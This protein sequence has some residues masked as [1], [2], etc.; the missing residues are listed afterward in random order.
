M[1]ANNEN[2]I[3]PGEGN[4][5]TLQIPLEIKIDLG[6]MQVIGDNLFHKGSSGSKFFVQENDIQNVREFDDVN[7][8]L[9]RT[10]LVKF[11]E[12]RNSDYYNEDEDHQ[13]RDKYFQPINGSASAP[14]FYRQLN[15][16]VSRTHK[17]QLKYKP[18]V[19]LYPDVDL[20][21]DKTIHSIYSGIEYESEKLILDDF[22][23]DQER[24]MQLREMMQKRV[25]WGA[26]MLAQELD[27]LESSLPYNCEH[28]V[29]QSWFEKR[30]P[31]RGDLHHLFAC[32]MTCNSFRGNIPYWRGD[33]NGTESYYLPIQ[34]QFHSPM[35]VS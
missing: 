5:I 27:L 9:L 18:A 12:S 31:M 20:Q 16:L 3:R 28:V 33:S 11:E 8:Q 25:S 32:E 30:E 14:D 6:N 17:T 19:H 35:C 29:P 2:K 13:N 1:D 22:R 34:S 10:A 4:I 26:E 7:A 21:P 23:I 24:G 15:E